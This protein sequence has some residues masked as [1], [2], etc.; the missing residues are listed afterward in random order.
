MWIALM[1]AITM[2]LVASILLFRVR[3]GGK[4]L[5]DSDWGL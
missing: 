2:P 5:D 1:A 3:L 4:N